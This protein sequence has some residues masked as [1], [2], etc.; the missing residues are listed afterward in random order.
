GRHNDASGDRFAAQAMAQRSR[1]RG[2]PVRLR[3]ST[4]GYANH[5]QRL[6]EFTR[7][8]AW[9]FCPN[10]DTGTEPNGRGAMYR[11]LR[12]RIIILQAT[13]VVVLA[14]VAAQKISF[15]AKRSPALDPREFPDLQQ[16]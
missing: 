15:P 13:V 2:A 6:S 1:Q 7:Q 8:T 10:L 14:F 4:C 16:F 3:G 5:R 11:S 12:W 9:H